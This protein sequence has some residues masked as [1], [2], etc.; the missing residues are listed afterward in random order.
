M[1]DCAG[2]IVGNGRVLIT[3]VDGQL[4][5]VRAEAQRYKLVS[6]LRIFTS[7]EVWSHPALVGN[8]LYVRGSEEI[9]CLLLD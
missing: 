9:R 3:T 1:I 2:L 7:G 6:R 8:R 5:L 4:L